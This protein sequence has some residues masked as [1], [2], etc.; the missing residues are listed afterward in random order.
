MVD[1]HVDRLDVEAQ[2]CAQLTSTNSS[3]GLIYALKKIFMKKKI[4]FLGYSS[5]KTNLIKFLRKKKNI[6]K[7][8]GNS[9]INR[10]TIEKADLVISFGYRK[11][12][13]S[14]LFKFSKRPI[15]NLHISFL[16]FNRGSHPNFWSFIENTPK[17]VT[18]HEIDKK[19]DKGSIVFRKKITFIRKNNLTFKETHNILIKEIERL[20][21]KNYNKIISGNYLKKK[22]KLKGTIHKSSELPNNIKSWNVKISDYLKSYNN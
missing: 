22:I 20:F 2:Q 16:P 15:L 19:I 8:L 6:V 9:V 13:K 10:K 5:K 17:G 14:S 11:I 21:I 4:I 12:I 18:I 7:V 1:H 3:I